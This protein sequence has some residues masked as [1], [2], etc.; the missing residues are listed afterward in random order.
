[1]RQIAATAPERDP[2]LDAAA[3]RA[4]SVQTKYESGALTPEQEAAFVL[5]E[6]GEFS[7]A[8]TDPVGSPNPQ[9]PLRTPG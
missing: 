7:E 2:K 3:R 1:L 6:S 5:L 4:Y 8:D 9:R